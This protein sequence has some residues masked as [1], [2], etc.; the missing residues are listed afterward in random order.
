MRTIKILGVG[1]GVWVAIVALGLIITFTVLGVQWITADAKGATA[2]RTRILSAETRITAYNHFFDACSGIQ[3]L[4]GT[5]ASQ[6]EVLEDAETPRE[7]ERIRTNIAGTKGLRLQ[8]IAKYNTDAGKD[9]TI[10][11]FR[12]LDLPHQLNPER[13]P[14]L[15][16]S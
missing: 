9:Y 4:E 12:D 11:Q 16:V 7:R 1:I 15:C 5:I 14:T 8:A 10:G 13:N 3:G 2:A 6:E